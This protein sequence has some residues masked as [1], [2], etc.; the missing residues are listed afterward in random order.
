MFSTKLMMMFPT[1]A[2]A[3]GIF[4]SP[5][6]AQV[7]CDMGGVPGVPIAGTDSMLCGT[8]ALRAGF[9]IGW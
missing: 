2:L 9:T 7:A 1:A 8:T 4:A 5:A 6:A 3:A